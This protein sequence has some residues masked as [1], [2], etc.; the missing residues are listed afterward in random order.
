[1]SVKNKVKLK[2]F[3]DLFPLDDSIKNDVQEIPLDQLKTFQNHPFKVIDDEKMAEMV[4]SIRESGILVPGICRKKDEGNYEII[5]GH[6]RHHAARLAGMITMPMMVKDVDDDEA[7]QY[8]V[9]S[10]IQRENILPSEKA[11]AYKMKYES[12]K[13]QGVYADTTSL[14]Q[15]ADMVGEN[16]KTV[17]RYIW[18]SRLIDELLEMVDSKSIPFG[19]GLDLSFLKESEQKMLYS[20]IQEK[21]IKLTVSMTRN[22]KEESKN[23]GLSSERI[24]EIL[25]GKTVSIKRKIQFNEKKL[26]KYFPKDM[27]EDEVEEI[28]IQLLEKWKKKQEEG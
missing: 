1:M 10:N 11:K 3:D 17:Q 13:H 6:R 16:S 23:V 7:I 19:Q 28:I 27:K 21:T 22:L 2:S 24:K 8:M 9:D 5:S 18:L 25:Y 26:E 14:E 4:E 15:L 12:M 20:I